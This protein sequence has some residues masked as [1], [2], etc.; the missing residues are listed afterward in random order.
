MRRLILLRHAKAIR[1]PGEEDF[2]RPLAAQGIA[3]AGIMGRVLAQAGLLPDRA[4]V[5]GALRTRQTWEEIAPSFPGAKAQVRRDLYLAEV[6]G[7]WA[8]V[9]GAGE[10]VDT[11]MVVAHNP[12]IHALASA[13]LRRNGAPPST[14]AKVERG[15]PTCTAAVFAID[16]AGRA[17]YDGLYLVAEHGG[18][19]TE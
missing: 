2:D 18:A 8:A 9:E 5:S 15:F 10:E 1:S 6:D 13:L 11:L 19:G 4:L 3:D 16:E 14:V 12:G 17:A 7:L